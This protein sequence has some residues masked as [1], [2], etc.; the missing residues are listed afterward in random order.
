MNYSLRSPNNT[1]R[2]SQSGA[3]KGSVLL[4]TQMIYIQPASIYSQ[5]FPLRR[6]KSSAYVSPTFRS[7]VCDRRPRVRVAPCREKCSSCFMVVS[8]AGT[9]LTD[10]LHPRDGA[11][12]I[13]P[14]F[15]KRSDVGEN[16]LRVVT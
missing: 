2:R 11:G 15:D 7:E 12:W 9:T 16:G 6:L 5:Q 1:G 4:G 13:Y 14:L 10:R 8:L 3:Y